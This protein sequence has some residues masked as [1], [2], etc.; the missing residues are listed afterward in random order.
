MA[1]AT[2][3]LLWI[4]AIVALV[5]SVYTILTH[6]P[7][8]VRWVKQNELRFYTD[9]G[10]LNG[11]YYSKV[12]KEGVLIKELNV[13]SKQK[14]ISYHSEDLVTFVPRYI[15]PDQAWEDNL[16]GLMAE[17]SDG[18][19]LCIHNS[20]NING[21]K[22]KFTLARLG[23]ND[24]YWQNISVSVDIPSG[25]PNQYNIQAITCD[26]NTWYVLGTK[27]SKCLVYTSKD[28]GETWEHLPVP[29]DAVN[30][31][32]KVHIVVLKK[33]IIL[34][35][36]DN[37]DNMM[38]HR[39][40]DAGEKWATENIPYALQVQNVRYIPDKNC[41][42][43]IG[44]SDDLT[45]INNDAYA[46]MVTYDMGKTWT[47]IGEHAN[48]TDPSS[49]ARFQRF[50]D[51]DY[52][53]HLNM[54]IG[55]VKRDRIFVSKDLK[56]WR[57]IEGPLHSVTYDDHEGYIHRL[58]YAHHQKKLMCET[59]SNIFVTSAE[60]GHHDLVG[61]NPRPQ[62]KLLQTLQPIPEV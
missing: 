62:S 29:E 57:A 10:S 11:V 1:N 5:L 26:D 38:V 34:I 41:V 44:N 14:A 42:L 61:L 53:S 56:D 49:S 2:N 59:N 13:N 21:D 40:S 39:S 31:D 4:V 9:F 46:I 20:T 18:T 47:K 60:V 25:F 19:M 17:K 37:N 7:H 12:R 16:F 45:T 33:K 3:I 43:I 55:V 6:D 58:I 15:N 8:P 48:Q 52:I 32:H 24:V 50:I 27:N 51:V 54:Y 22:Q 28:N 30:T 23:P 35:H 36:F